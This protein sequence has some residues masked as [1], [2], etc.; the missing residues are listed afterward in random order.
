MKP[1]KGKPIT[2][3]NEFL[4]AVILVGPPG[5]GKGTQ[6]CELSIRFGVPHLS[7]G[8]LL[9]EAVRKRTAIGRVA[10]TTMDLGALVP[11]DLVCRIVEERIIEPDCANGFILDGFPRTVSQAVFL[12]RIINA[13]QAWVPVVLN[14]Q[15]DP[16][17]L[18]MRIL[19]RLICPRCRKIYNIYFRI[20][21]RAGFCDEDNERLTRRSDD[22]EES[23]RRR[24]AAYARQTQPLI[25]YYRMMG[26]V[27]DV[28][29]DAEPTDVT[30]RLDGLLRNLAQ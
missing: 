5:C 21:K 28:N 22:N 30:R 13:N 25:N 18:I 24:L 29:A 8:E 12:S 16:Q 26:V 9:R 19:G 23:I 27:R 17:V 15:L 20:P 1:P 10:K 14:M 11:D 2:N 4:P 6:A 3:K 7:T